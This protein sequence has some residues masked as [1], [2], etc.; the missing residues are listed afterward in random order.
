MSKRVEVL[1]TR[2]VILRFHRSWVPQI[3]IDWDKTSKTFYLNYRKI[4]KK[5][6]TVN[7]T[8]FYFATYLTS[9]IKIQ[10]LTLKISHSI[11]F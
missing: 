11:S 9:K 2:I 3:F 4:F 10:P 8:N 6:F 7:F 1:E 5:E